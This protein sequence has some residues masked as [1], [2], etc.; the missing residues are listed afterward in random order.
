[1]KARFSPT[2][3]SKLKIVSSK[4]SIAN[5]LLSWFNNSEKLYN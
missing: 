4:I 5:L 1:M 3:T 2:T